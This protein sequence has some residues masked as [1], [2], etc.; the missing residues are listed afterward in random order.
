MLKFKNK[1]STKLIEIS[2]E[3]QSTKLIEMLNNNIY[4]MNLLCK[5]I[6]RLFER[7]FGI[8]CFLVKTI[9]IQ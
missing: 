6:I 7:N 3:K 5:C 8:L 2:T 4:F 9:E 1:L